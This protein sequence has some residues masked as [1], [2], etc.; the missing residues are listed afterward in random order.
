MNRYLLSLNLG[1]NKIDDIGAGLLAEVS[2][3]RAFFFLFFFV[4]FTCKSLGA[5]EYFKMD[6]IRTGGLFW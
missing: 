2:L 6:S 5:E 1:G 4:K 3:N